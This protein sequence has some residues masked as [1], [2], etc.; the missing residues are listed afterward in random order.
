M[1]EGEPLVKLSAREESSDSVPSRGFRRS[2]E[3]RLTNMFFSVG[4]VRV[5]SICM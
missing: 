5:D 4:R 2:V 1:T 3:G